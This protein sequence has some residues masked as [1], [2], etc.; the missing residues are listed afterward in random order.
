MC[1]GT[2]LV[3][4][5]HGWLPCKTT[6]WMQLLVCKISAFSLVFGNDGITKD[7]EWKVHYKFRDHFLLSKLSFTNWIAW[8]LL[9]WSLKTR[10]WTLNGEMQFGMFA[11]F[12]KKV[13][14]LWFCPNTVVYH[15][16]I[17]YLYLNAVVI[18]QVCG[19]SNKNQGNTRVL[20]LFLFFIFLELSCF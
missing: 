11:L 8:V 4:I 2:A 14:W 7:K 17:W 5:S 12:Y 18:L 1:F 10:P 15:T 3:R 9:S 16:L 20:L 19:T 13:F 6:W